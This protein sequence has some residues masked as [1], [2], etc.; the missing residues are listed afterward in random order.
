MYVNAQQDTDTS[1]PWVD[2]VIGCLNDAQK[3][4]F[5]SL[6]SVLL[7]LA[8]QGSGKTFMMG[9]VATYYV[10][11]FPE[12]IGLLAANTY[13]QLTRS[14]LKT[15][16]DVWKQWF[17]ITE[18][19]KHNPEGHYVFGVIPPGHFVRFHEFDN[20]RNI[21]SFRNGAVL[22]T[23]SLDNY[24]ALDGMNIAY[25]LLDETKDTKEEAVK[26]VIL[27]RLRQRAI[28]RD[29]KA[30]NPLYIFTSPAKVPWI[31]EW[32]C[33]DE[34]EAEIKQTVYNPPDFFRKE[35]DGRLVTIA[36]TYLN[37]ANLPSDFIP[38]KLRDLPPALVDMLVYGDPLKRSGGEF[39]KEFVRERD[40]KDIAADYDPKLPLHLTLDFNVLPYI[41]LLVFQ[42][43]GKQV[44]QVKEFCLPSPDNTTAK[45]CRA[46]LKYFKDHQ[47]GCY[48]YG[49]PSGRAQDTR[50]EEGGNDYTIAKRELKVWR[51]KDRVSKKAPGVSMSGSFL[52]T[53]LANRFEGISL[54]LDKACKKTVG[55]F[56][57]CKEAAD[58]TMMKPKETDQQGRTYEKLGHPLDATR[59]LMVQA[60]P[61]EWL[62]F[63][64]NVSSSPPIVVARGGSNKRF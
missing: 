5:E 15:I 28:E 31:N 60:F 51:P 34:H 36:A 53:I 64:K 25:A 57:Y 56:T 46:A 17:G 27:G 8:G 61:K 52:D 35:E 9:V 1:V 32:F 20:Y 49:D 42:I 14:T 48:L 13:G 54:Q 45:V 62:K 41:T 50:T 37:E 24:K 16:R 22:Y 63:S 10:T 55:D 2:T 18:Y 38:N 3:L 21:I 12:A 26:E 39:I 33:L 58:G 11:H 30:V 23:G 4:I 44:K 6:C 40:V 29:G 43:R 59:Y 19:S 7:Y 47:G